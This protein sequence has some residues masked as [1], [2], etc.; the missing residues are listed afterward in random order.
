MISPVAPPQTGEALALTDCRVDEL[1]LSDSGTVLDTQTQIEL[2]ALILSV[3]DQVLSTT[4]NQVLP[5]LPIPRFTMSASLA[6][7]G[8]PLGSELGMLNLVLRAEDNHLIL[9]GDFGF[10]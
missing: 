7:F 1:H 4:A 6:P 9:E 2:E 3:L 8:I 5:L 10:R